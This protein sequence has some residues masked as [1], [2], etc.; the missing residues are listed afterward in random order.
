MSADENNE[1]E[2]AEEVMV[3]Q[4]PNPQ[5]RRLLLERLL[6]S[7]DAASS[8][9]PSAW[10]ATLFSNGFRLNVG[11]VEALVFLDGR[12]R[13]NLVGSVGAAP[14]IGATFEQASYGSLPQPLCA[15]VGSLPQYAEVAAAVSNAHAAFIHLA[16]HSPSGKPRN[17][18]PFRRSH[19][20]GLIRY[21]RAAVGRY[22]AA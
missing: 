19:S 5:D 2:A 17:G 22:L 21:V 6:A 11:Q 10:G 8:V 14:F 13:A 16:A 20:E 15:F 12:L 3:E 1:I 9:A 18:S 4:C 7:A